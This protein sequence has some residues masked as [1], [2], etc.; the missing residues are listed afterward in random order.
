MKLLRSHF[1]ETLETAAAKIGIGKSTMKVVCR[2]LGLKK[3]PY[4]NKGK[5]RTEKKKALV[6]LEQTLRQSQQQQLLAA[7]RK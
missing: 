7:G 5:K 1:H 2:K 4:T 6:K 3:W